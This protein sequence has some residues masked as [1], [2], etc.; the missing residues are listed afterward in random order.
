MLAAWGRDVATL[1]SALAATGLIAVAWMLARTDLGRYDLGVQD[2]VFALSIC[3]ASGPAWSAWQWLRLRTDGATFGGRRT[4]IASDGGSHL[5]AS[6]WFRRWALAAVHP[7]TLPLWLWA[8]MVLTISGVDALA[9]LAVLPLT[10][11]LTGGV[12]MLGSMVLLLVRPSAA[13]LHVWFTHASFGG[14]R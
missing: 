9:L 2:A 12:L 4:T 6:S 13:P 8:T 5:V 1:A 11:F 7:T 10:M 3:L 14:G